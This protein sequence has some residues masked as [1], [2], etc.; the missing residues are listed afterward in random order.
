MAISTPNCGTQ[1]I[2][3]PCGSGM[4]EL[5]GVDVAVLGVDIAVRGVDISS[6]SR[7]N[8]PEDGH[9]TIGQVSHV[10]HPVMG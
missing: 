6:G 2:S 1:K 8:V 4:E 7:H 10:I 3:A 5:L 9:M